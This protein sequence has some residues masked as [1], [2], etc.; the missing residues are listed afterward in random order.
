MGFSVELLATT[1]AWRKARALIDPRFLLAVP[2]V[3]GLLLRLR[4]AWE[5][6]STSIRTIPDDAFYY[7][8]ISRNVAN[9][10]N[11]SF[12]GET[13][14]NGFHPLWAALLTPLYLFVDDPELAV[15]LGLTM[16]A[17][18]GVATVIL[19]FL[20]IESLTENRWAA[21]AGST[22]F[23]IHP[24]V[25]ADSVNGM[26]TAVAVFMVALTT[27]LFVRL[28][29]RGDEPSRGQFAWLG[30][31]AGFM[32]LARTDTILILALLLLYFAVRERS[33]EGLWGPVV[34]GG[35]AMLV[36]APW[37][38]WSLVTFGTVIQISGVAVPQIE[39]QVFLAANGD[40][41]IT[42]ITQ[43][44]DVT[45]D[46][47]YDALPR[48]YFIRVGWPKASILLVSGITLLLMAAVPLGAPRS[49]FLRQMGI[50]LVPVAG[51]V[52]MLLFHSA[53]RWHLRGWYFS[54]AALFGAV[55]FG[56]ALDYILGAL[57]RIRDWF[58]G[59]EDI[60]AAGASRGP[61]RF[62]WPF[63]SIQAGA[64]ILILAAAVF[65]YGPQRADVWVLRLPHRQNMLEAALWLEAN[66]D[67]EARIGS[68][69]AGIIGYFSERTVI[70]L[71]GVV[72]EH[73]YRARREGKTVEYVCSNQID[74]VVDLSLKRWESVPCGDPPRARFELLTT[75][76][77]RLAYFR[78]GQVDVLMLVPEP[79]VVPSQQP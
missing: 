39:R 11:V 29:T 27:L 9:G 68:Y 50:L 18:L 42:Q 65:F 19:A 23:A 28:G 59:A 10:N 47:F 14:T 57:Q 51:I 26:E 69:N 72:N 37:A 55:F 76:G 49:R 70:N 33:M 53:I 44:W 73:A 77:R 5:D 56:V 25:V 74:Y 15:H 22:L 48:S 62:A 60:S 34:A 35:V 45:R 2:V 58:L 8:Q 52:V 4:V 30:V 46:A 17:L 21:L 61:N 79:A 43:S 13:L 16:G 78:G 66:T 1:R 3:A 6:I 32:V 54:P 67:E 36:V 24:W 40:S 63:S 71:D 20:V 75:I 38:I 31:S 7:F 64:F 41:F 12:D